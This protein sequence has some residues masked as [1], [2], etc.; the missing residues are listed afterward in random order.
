MDTIC[1]LC[2]NDNGT[3]SRKS[4]KVLCDNCKR[5]LLERVDIQDCSVI[6]GGEITDYCSREHTCHAGY[7]LAWHLGA[8]LYLEGGWVDLQDFYGDGDPEFPPVTP[9][10]PDWCVIRQERR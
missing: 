6:T 8:N 5:L 10:W 9:E 4:Q 7:K 1:K 2:G 3:W